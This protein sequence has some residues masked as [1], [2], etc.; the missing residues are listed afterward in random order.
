MKIRFLFYLCL[1][2]FT[3][4]A[5]SQAITETEFKEI[6]TSITETYASS[7]TNALQLVNSLLSSDTVIFSLEQRAIITNYKAWF[8][9]EN[10][11]LE[12]AMKTLVHFMDIALQSSNKDL[13]Y[14]YL[15]ISGG[16]YARLG[17]YQ[18]HYTI[19]AM[20]YL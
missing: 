18:M 12:Q 13:M 20:H 3:S 1:M 4:T 7:P 6:E 16:I 8:L 10:D 2:L 17:M 11:E 14:G 15:N 5:L 9:L 19:I